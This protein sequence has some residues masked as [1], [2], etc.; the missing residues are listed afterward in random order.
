MLTCE[1]NVNNDVNY[2]EETAVFKENPEIFLEK[3]F[4][5][6]EKVPKFVVC[7]LEMK[8]KIEKFLR[9]HDYTLIKSFSHF[10]SPLQDIEP[11]KGKNVLL[12]EKR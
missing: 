8:P 9:K 3:R 7:L 2:E 5:K 11:W 6:I 1:P 4:K 12:F 10:T